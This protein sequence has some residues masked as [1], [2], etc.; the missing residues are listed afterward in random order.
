MRS[1][2]LNRGRRCTVM[3]VFPHHP[4]Q[5]RGLSW[6]TGKWTY[7]QCAEYVSGKLSVACWGPCY[8]FFL[9]KQQLVFCIKTEWFDF[10]CTFPN[11]RPCC[12]NSKAM[13]FFLHEALLT[14]FYIQTHG[15]NFDFFRQAGVT[16]TV[17]WK[18]LLLRDTLRYIQNGLRN[19]F[20]GENKYWQSC[21]FQK[22]T[23]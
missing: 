23:C 13:N 1:G 10:R 19:R 21:W 20:R 15:I 4:L 5:R 7:D 14:I 18:F 12:W 8:F 17:K 22:V 3:W 11:C 2:E 16:G 9:F 6:W